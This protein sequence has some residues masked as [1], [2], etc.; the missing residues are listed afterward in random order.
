MWYLSGEPT[1]SIF[2]AE[3][4]RSEKKVKQ[5]Q[6]A[7]RQE[8]PNQTFM[9]LLERNENELEQQRTDSEFPAA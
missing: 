9:K 2:R 5:I 8:I 6:Q 1:G 3:V 7:I 4:R